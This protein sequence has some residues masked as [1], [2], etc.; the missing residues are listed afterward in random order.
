[1]DTRMLVKL[2]IGWKLLSTIPVHT[3]TNVPISDG[4]EAQMSLV[5]YTRQ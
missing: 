4:V 1:M 3:I 2:I 5:I